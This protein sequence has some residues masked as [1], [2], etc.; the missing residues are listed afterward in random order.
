MTRLSCHR[1]RSNELRKPVAAT[2][3]AEEDRELVAD[4][5]TATVREARRQADQTCPVL[6][7][8]VG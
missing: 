6:L 5:L 1:F 3:A 8:S 7:V 2:G 4:Q